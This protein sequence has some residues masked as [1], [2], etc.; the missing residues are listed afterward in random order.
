MWAL[1]FSLSCVFKLTV[2]FGPVLSL[3]LVARE[4]SIY[5]FRPGRVNIDS[6]LVGLFYLPGFIALR[7]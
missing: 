6:F 2:V 1:R 3:S 5:R 4:L 7:R